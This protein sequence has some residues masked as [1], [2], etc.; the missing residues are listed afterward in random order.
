MKISA[1]VAQ[2]GNVLSTLVN[3]H[4]L[5]YLSFMLSLYLMNITT[6][7]LWYLSL[8]LERGGSCAPV[9]LCTLKEI[10]EASLNQNTETEE[11]TNLFHTLQN[12]FQK[13]L[14]CVAHRLKKERE[15]G[16]QVSYYSSKCYVIANV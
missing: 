14:E 10:I 2:K 1:K 6:F 3:Y 5:L 7:I 12:V 11:V 9:L 16:I 8:S 4:Y 13:I 15:E